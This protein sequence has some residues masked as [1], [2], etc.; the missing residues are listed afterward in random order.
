[1]TADPHQIEL[2][3]MKSISAEASE[4]LN[5]LRS[6]KHRQWIKHGGDMQAGGPNQ[7]Q[8]Y[9]RASSVTAAGDIKSSFPNPS[10]AE[11]IALGFPLSRLGQSQHAAGLPSPPATGEKAGLGACDECF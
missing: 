5:S 10:K 3:A 2:R 4:Q 8:K 1:M 11:H 7:A 9:L 6:T